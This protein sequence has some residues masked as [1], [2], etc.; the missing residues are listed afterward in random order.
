[1]ATKKRR[2]KRLATPVQQQ[3]PAVWTDWLRDLE[4][5]ANQIPQPGEVHAVQQDRRK[6]RLGATR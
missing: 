4:A 5:E 6:Q 3:T 1:M 2:P